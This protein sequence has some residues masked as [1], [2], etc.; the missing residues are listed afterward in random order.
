[1]NAAKQLIRE[2]R[3]FHDQFQGLGNSSHNTLWTNIAN[4]VFAMT[5]FV[6]TANQCKSK[7]TSLKRGYENMIRIARN[8]PENFPVACP[9][10]FDRA[11]FSEMNDRF[12]MR[13]GNCLF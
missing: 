6:A 8:N 3:A 4:N 11:C 5:G 10:S 12:W 13:T 2:R 7:W 9:N 1:M